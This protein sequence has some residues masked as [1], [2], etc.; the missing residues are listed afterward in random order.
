MDEDEYE[1][2]YGRG[3][4]M[5]NKFMKNGWMRFW[6]PKGKQIHPDNEYS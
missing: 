2:E 5:E 3:I 6:Y 1:Q 4:S